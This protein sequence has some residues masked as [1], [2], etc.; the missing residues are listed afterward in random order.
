M[1]PCVVNTDQKKCS[2]GATPLLEK[3][4]RLVLEVVKAHIEE[5][6]GET[7]KNGNSGVEKRVLKYHKT[8][9]F[10]DTQ[11]ACWQRKTE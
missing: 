4:E 6:L 8:I 7:K 11:A 3:M 5:F 2:D 1:R 10:T 9:G